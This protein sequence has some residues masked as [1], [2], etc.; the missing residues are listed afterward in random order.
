MVAAAGLDP[1]GLEEFFQ[2]LAHEPGTQ[3]PGMLQW[4]ST[5]PGHN[6]RIAAL[7]RLIPTLP[8]GPQV[9][10]ATPWAQVQSELNALGPIPS[11]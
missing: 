11:R 8:R 7:E 1:R 2:L 4:M 3:M 10:I 9:P 5:H 6:D